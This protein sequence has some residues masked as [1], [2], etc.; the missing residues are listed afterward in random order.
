MARQAL[1]K[2]IVVLL[3]EQQAEAIESDI[4]EDFA[5]DFFLIKILAM[6][7][8]RRFTCDDLFTFNS[9]NLDYFTETVSLFSLPF[10][11]LYFLYVD[12]YYLG[13]DDQNVL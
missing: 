3:S 11:E 13:P 5:I 4:E 1:V 7:T 10:K 9:V 8:L 6:T 12:F 2:F